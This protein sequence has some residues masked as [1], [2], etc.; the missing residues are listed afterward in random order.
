[1]PKRKNR[2][3]AV[4]DFETDPFL[5]GRVP[6]PFACGILWRHVYISF[7]GPRAAA[8]AIDY[9]RSIKVPLV[10]YAHNGGKFDFFF[11]WRHLENPLKLINSRIVSARCGIHEFRDS[12]AIMPF[13]LATYKKTKIDYAMFEEGVRENHRVE[14]QQ[15]LHDDCQ[16]LYDLCTV[17]VK[18]FGYKLTIAGTAMTELQKLHKQEK[19][20]ATHDSRYRRY[21]FGGRVQCFETG[22]LT[23][24]F[25]VY[26]VNSMYPSTMLNYD[27]PIGPEYLHISLPELD[28]DGW[29]DGFSGSLYFATVQGHNRGALPSRAD[30]GSLS[31]DCPYGVFNTTSHELR[32][33]LSLGLFT[34]EKILECSIPLEV[35]RF[36]KFVL[37]FSTEKADFKRSGDRINELLSKYVLNSAYGKFGQDPERFTDSLI[38]IEGQD[39]HP[40]F[41]D[42]ANPWQLEHE[43]S[44]YCIYSKPAPQKIYHDVAIAA[45]VTSA[46]RSV[47][48]R[49]IAGATRP[50]YCD[51]DSIICEGLSNVD[52][53]EYTLGAWKLEA[54]GT[55][56]AIAG[57]KLYALYDEELQAPVKWASKGT[58]LAPNDIVA[59]ASG[60]TIRW[61]SMAPNFRL[62]NTVQFTS[63][64]SRM[65]GKKRP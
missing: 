39:E 19:C 45:S 55:H 20:N 3:T 15:Y 32:T 54:T 62:D 30:D 12:W 33:A 53:D 38:V 14:I 5:Y 22:I 57:K 47:L 10:I 52:F 8:Q 36:E 44:E 23:G 34:V 63:R 31:F 46:A 51:T 21:Y 59:I 7:W 13:A 11:L 58:K 42:P 56:A 2:E 16:D 25:K 64:E 50:I 1:M 40:D 6:A 17:F 35:Q 9:L 60:A 4:I 61:D 28:S 27:H 49:A 48:M 26:D 24:G 29:I 37:Q 18:R 43:S 41:G 65:T